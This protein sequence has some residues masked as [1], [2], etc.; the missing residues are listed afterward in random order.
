MCLSVSVSVSV[1]V[2]LCLCVCLLVCM[3]LSILF[4][5]GYMALL[6]LHPFSNNKGNFKL[7]QA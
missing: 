4:A 1:S 7:T 2:N 3:C 5:E 6:H